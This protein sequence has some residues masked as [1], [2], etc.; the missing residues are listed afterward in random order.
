MSDFSK[1]F[2]KAGG[3]DILRQ[4]RR[5]HV[6][7]FAL[8]ETMILGFS[9]KSLEIVRLAV[10]NKI[11][12]KL[13]KKYRKKIAAFKA[14]IDKENKILPHTTCNKVWFCWFQGIE[15]APDL[16]KN[17]YRSLKE[18]L[19]NR[20]IVIITEEN[21]KDYVEFPDY[22]IEKY[23][24][25]II[26]KTH[27]S[28]LLRLQ[29]LIKYGG[30]WIDATVFCSGSDIPEYMLNSELFLFQNLK[31][32]LDGQA[33]CISSWF[34]TAKS[35]NS[36]LILT[37]DL[38]FDYWIK[39][40]NLI[41]YFLLHDFM[42]LALEAYPDDWNKIVPFANSVPHI[43]LLRLYEEYDE[44]LWKAIKN[45][46]PFHKVSY[47]LDLVEN[48]EANCFMKVIKQDHKNSEKSFD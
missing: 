16:I 2:K 5:A 44:N 25:G 18:N 9:K 28:D 14:K 42:Q 17:C 30:T 27:F 21:Y 20:E 34:I 7:C 1:L 41:D 46:T 47:K 6:L 15:N 40:K 26:T 23:K 4:Y 32:G 24:K 45:M 22:I 13:R 43:L 10:Q 38:L 37:R 36:V 12:S 3:K 48:R 19:A 29:L 11:V 31:P 39:K 35:N 8:F 33:T